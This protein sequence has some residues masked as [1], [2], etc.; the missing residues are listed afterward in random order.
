VIAGQ[1]GAKVAK[2]LIKMGRATDDQLSLKT[3]INI[4]DV[5][6]ILYSL[7]DASLISTERVRDEKTGWFIFYWT[8][9]L[10]AVEG[11]V[12]SR[13]RK[14]LE[15]LKAR[16]KYEQN[17]DFYD[18]VNLQCK[19]HTPFEEAIEYMFR[20]PSCGSDLAYVD[21]SNAVEKLQRKIKELEGET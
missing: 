4:N 19:R 16:L 10:D 11:F 14:V 12:V 18:C 17:H 2:V 8:P 20:C 9:Q 15:K 3:N 13:R 21:N 5:R 7:H 6:R 1:E